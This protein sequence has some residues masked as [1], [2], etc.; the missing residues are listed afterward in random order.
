MTH[1]T[2]RRLVSELLQLVT[3]AERLVSEIVETGASTHQ[4]VRVEAAGTRALDHLASA[5]ELFQQLIDEHDDDLS[6]RRSRRKP[7]AYTL[8]LPARRRA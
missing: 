4:R 1:R 2:Q 3:R 7:P 8:I 6:R 5:G